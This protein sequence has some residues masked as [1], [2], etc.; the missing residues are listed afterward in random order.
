MRGLGAKGIRER[1]SVWRG[2]QSGKGEGQKR[3]NENPAPLVPVDVSR[4]CD[5]CPLPPLH[6]HAASYNHVPRARYNHR[7]TMRDGEG[8]H[9]WMMSSRNTTR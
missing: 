9:G 2:R 7:E 3:R 8:H 5:P 4:V 6:E 1:V